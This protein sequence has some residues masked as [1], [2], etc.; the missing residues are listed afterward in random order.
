MI[1][2]FAQYMFEAT[3]IIPL[4]SSATDDDWRIQSG[5]VGKNEHLKLRK[6][7]NT[8]QTNTRDHRGE[9]LK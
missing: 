4:T 8:I 6:D 5:D 7:S 9:D 3:R 1:G 2:I